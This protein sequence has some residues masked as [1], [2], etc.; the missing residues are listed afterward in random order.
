MIR[1]LLVALVT[2]G[3]Q[4]VEVRSWSFPQSLPSWNGMQWSIRCIRQ[5]V[6]LSCPRVKK[7]FGTNDCSLEWIFEIKSIDSFRA[8]WLAG[9]NRLERAIGGSAIG[10]NLVTMSGP[11][12]RRICTVDGFVP[13]A[14]TDRVLTRPFEVKATEPKRPFGLQD[15]RFDA[16]HTRETST[17][18]ATMRGVSFLGRGM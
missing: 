12:I 15:Q 4:R 1:P 6:S 14:V 2:S 8:A 18:P 11:D 9:R 5:Q 10:G 7:S 13:I 16:N 3:W 17:Y